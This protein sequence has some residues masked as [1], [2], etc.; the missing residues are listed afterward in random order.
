MADITVDLKVRE[1]LIMQAWLRA[2]K[3][4][5]KRF[6]ERDFTMIVG[7]SRPQLLDRPSFLDACDSRFRCFGFRFGEAYARQYNRI[8]WFAAEIELELKLG[9]RDWS[10]PFWIT[11]LW[12]KTTFGRGWKLAERS[13]SLAEPDEEF[14]HAIHRLQLWR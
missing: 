9:G 3:T 10:G 6:I 7:A 13:L 8:A 4:G 1:D 5:L 12:R 14:S 11:D 2:D